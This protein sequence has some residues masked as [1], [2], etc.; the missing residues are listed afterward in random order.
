MLAKRHLRRVFGPP[1][2]CGIK[3]RTGN[4]LNVLVPIRLLVIVLAARA[5]ADVAMSGL[6]SH[7]QI[8]ESVLLEL[9]GVHSLCFY[10]IRRL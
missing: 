10:R 9:S 8:S 4:P 1:P 2:S 5:V 6:M 3:F 7:Q